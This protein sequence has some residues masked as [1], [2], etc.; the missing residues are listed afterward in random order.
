M[1]IT[2]Q[3]YSQDRIK[4]KNIN[5]STGKLNISTINRKLNNMNKYK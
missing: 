2:I 1:Y 4:Y 5:R 3:N